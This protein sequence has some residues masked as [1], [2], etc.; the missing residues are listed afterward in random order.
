MGSRPPNSDRDLFL[1]QVWPWE[2]LWS[3]FSVQPQSWSSQSNH[4]AGQL[5]YKIHFSLHV[6]IWSRNG[7]LFLCRI[8][9]KHFKTMTIFL[10]CCQ[11]IKHPHIEFFHFFNL[12]QMPNGHRMVDT[13]FFSNFS[14]SCKRI[15]FHDPL[16]CSLS[17]SD[18]QLLPFSSSR[19]LFLWQNFLNHHCIVHSLAVPGSN[20]FVDVASCLHCFMTHFELK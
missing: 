1:E 2:V 9:R 14:C 5:S 16:S 18:G 10:I 8:K 7:S 17:T 12:L 19:L 11:F 15:S 6:I 20:A 3:F 13:D 4:W